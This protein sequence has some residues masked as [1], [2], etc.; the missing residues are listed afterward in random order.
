MPG[1]RLR[2]EG[3][4]DS[5]MFPFCLFCCL[6]QMDHSKG[7]VL[8]DLRLKKLPS[9][10]HR[11]KKGTTRMTKCT[12]IFMFMQV[13]RFCFLFELFF[14]CCTQKENVR[15][16]HHFWIF[17]SW[18]SICCVRNVAELSS[19][20]C[21]IGSWTCFSFWRPFT[22]YPSGFL[23]LLTELKLRAQMCP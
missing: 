7:A 16:W 5:Y 2:L 8:E 9:S 10:G 22:S 17:S 4:N 11:V 14:L 1:G 21:I 19:K 13:F 18:L 6:F 20:C 3:A 15:S 12:D 23:S